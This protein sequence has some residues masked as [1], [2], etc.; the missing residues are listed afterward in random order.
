MISQFINRPWRHLAFGALVFSLTG[1]IPLV[2]DVYKADASM[3][4]PFESEPGIGPRTGVAFS[5]QGV[6]IGLIAPYGLAIHF[7]VPEGRT[8]TLATNHAT[9]VT[10]GTKQE[11]PLAFT[12]FRGSEPGELKVSE[13]SNGNIELRGETFQIGGLRHPIHYQTTK[14]IDAG[15]DEFRIVFP[16]FEVNGETCSVPEVVF[17]PYKRFAVY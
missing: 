12:Y 6:K 2:Y 9:L 4:Q 17:K 11:F 16:S 14:E 13:Q 15:L 1:C 7:F 3:G 8:V 5:C 10:D